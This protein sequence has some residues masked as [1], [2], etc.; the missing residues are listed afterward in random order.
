MADLTLDQLTPRNIA[1]FWAKVDKAGPN[2]CWLWTGCHNWF[3]LIGGY[4]RIGIGGRA[5]KAHII[6]LIIAGRPKPHPKAVTMHT[7]DV[8]NCVNPDHLQWGTHAD[9]MADA[10]SK[11]RAGQVRGGQRITNE[12]ATEI[13]RSSEKTSIL[14]ARYGITDSYVSGI[15]NGRYRKFSAT[16]DSIS[17]V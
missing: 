5:R 2:G 4:G 15:R 9:N 12:Q 6:S 16:R 10:A 1:N 11:G 8:R 13:R 14:A 7:C 3:G 17:T